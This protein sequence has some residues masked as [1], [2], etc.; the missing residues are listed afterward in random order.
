M[1]KVKRVWVVFVVEVG[2]DC[3]GFCFLMCVGLLWVFGEEGGWF[4]GD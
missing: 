4:R 2:G 1:G 3:D